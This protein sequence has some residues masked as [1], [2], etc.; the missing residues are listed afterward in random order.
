MCGTD[1]YIERRV[2]KASW[3]RNTYL[4]FLFA[5]FNGTAYGVWGNPLLPS[6]IFVVESHG[7][8]RSN[9]TADPRAADALSKVGYAEA[10]Q[11]L[12]QAGAAV[13]AGCFMDRVLRKG[14]RSVMLKL[15]SAMMALAALVTVA[16]VVGD[17]GDTWRWRLLCVA[18][19]CWG[20][21]SGMV[22]PPREAIFADSIST[23]E[24]ARVYTYRGMIKTAARARSS[25]VV[26]QP[27]W[28]ACTQPA[29]RPAVRSSRPSHLP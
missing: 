25:C 28:I 13:A 27:L 2:G 11:G 19:A 6:Y 5:L 26:T 22:G 3:N 24:R 9:A 14:R 20:L 23:G 16:T 29:V 17:W 4:A 21:Q 7:A 15:S 8:L 12:T 10:L 18:C 1:G